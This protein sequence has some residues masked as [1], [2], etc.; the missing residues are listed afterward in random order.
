MDRSRYF[1]FSTDLY[2]FDHFMGK[3]LGT[4]ADL[5]DSRS[6]EIFPAESMPDGRTR[7]RAVVEDNTGRKSDW[8]FVMVVRTF[9]KYKG[10]WCTHRLMRSDSPHLDKV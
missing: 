8:T 10:M 7:V 5:I 3:T 9:S 4:F 1:G 2:H 6:Y